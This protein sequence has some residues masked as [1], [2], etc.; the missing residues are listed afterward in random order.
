M[1]RAHSALVGTAIRL[2]ECMGLHKDGSNYG[3]TPVEIHVRRIVWYQIGMLDIRTCESQGPRPGIREGEFDTKFPLNADDNDLESYNPPRQSADRFTDMTFTLIRM[4]C[5]EMLRTLWFDRPKLETKQISLTTILGK[6]ENFRRSMT[7]KYEPLLDKS[8]PIQH[9]ASLVMSVYINR[10][11]IMV[12]HR[13]HNSVATRIPDRLRQIIITTGTDLIESAMLFETLPTVSAWSWLSGALQQYHTAFLLLA[14]VFTYPMRRESDRIW[15][16]LDYVFEVPSSLHRDQKARLILTEMRDKMGAYRDA[17]KLRAPTTMMK[18]L[19]QAPPRT[20]ADVLAAGGPPRASY[21]ITSGLGAAFGATLGEGRADTGGVAGE[22]V[23]PPKEL[24]FPGPNGE[25]KAPEEMRERWRGESLEPGSVSGG[26]AS[27]SSRPRYAGAL[28]PSGPG[29]DGMLSPESSVFSAPPGIVGGGNGSGGSGS[30]SGV[31]VAA[32]RGTGSAS[33]AGAS[34]SLT[35]ELMADIDWVSSLLCV[36]VC[37]CVCFRFQ[38][39]KLVFFSREELFCK[40]NFRLLRLP[41]CVSSEAF[42]PWLC[43]PD[44]WY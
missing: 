19:G 32:T 30:G 9:A 26:S 34:P 29:S 38:I 36:C 40:G 3:M 2:A 11:Y 4:E 43:L 13:Y 18:R 39:P 24:L 14:E 41:S 42:F 35:D 20:K 16:V 37:V 15:A 8:I 21:G 31:S 27:G 44:R 6:I 33:D 5:C 17:R 1:S 28:Y 7:A 10:L 12:L 23:K 22:E 25:V